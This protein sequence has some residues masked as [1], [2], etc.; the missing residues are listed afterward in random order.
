[1]TPKDPLLDPMIDPTRDPAL[2]YP[3]T[4][5]AAA[6]DSRFDP[7]LDPVRAASY[8]PR[9]SR[10]PGLLAAGIVGA[11][12]GGVVLVNLMDEPAVHSPTVAKA[13]TGSPGAVSS[14]Q[15]PLTPGMTGNA[16]TAGADSSSSTAGAAPDAEITAAVK[17]ALAAD[18]ALAPQAID[19]RTENG[20]VTLT[21]PAADE[22]SRER[23]TVLASAPDGVS[24]TAW[25]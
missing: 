9:R 24:T 15:T 14:A 23:A 17:A 16:A 18:P 12:I 25:S 3:R 4:V 13:P 2:D 20:V 19:V 10:W 8:R 6:V 7:R 11:A 1:M 21:G 5:R 22:P